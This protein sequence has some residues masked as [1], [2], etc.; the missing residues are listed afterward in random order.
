MRRDLIIWSLV[1]SDLTKCGVG[2]HYT[3]KIIELLL[4]VRLTY[5]ER[6]QLVREL[7]ANNT[8]SLLD[9]NSIGDP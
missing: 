4:W 7:C 3:L 9:Y 2:T 6:S 8:C 5:L 1:R